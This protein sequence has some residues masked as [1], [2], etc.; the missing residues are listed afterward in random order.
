MRILRLGVSVIWTDVDIY[1]KVHPLSDMLATIRTDQDR[2]TRSIGK[3]TEPADIV[4]Q[5]NAPPAEWA[6]NGLL[7]INS[8]FYYVAAGPRSVRAFVAIVEHAGRSELS[9]QPSFYAVLCGEK[10]EHVD[11]E[12]ACENPRVPART[13]MLSRRVYPNGAMNISEIT[14]TSRFFSPFHL[15]TVG[16][17]GFHVHNIL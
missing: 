16:F 11:G 13:L 14:A 4:I 6:D 5:S 17:H 8:G 3:P 7:R 1:W 2:R 12:R 9:E 10:G 15:L